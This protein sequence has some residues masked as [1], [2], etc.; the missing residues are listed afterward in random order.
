MTETERKWQERHYK[1]AQ[2][3]AEKFKTHTESQEI[4]I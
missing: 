3:S 1:I 2:E 4:D